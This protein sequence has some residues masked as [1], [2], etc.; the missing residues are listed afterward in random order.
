M[1]TLALG[2]RLSEDIAR[3][4]LLTV[5]LAGR[6]APLVHR[7]PELIRAARRLVCSPPRV[8]VK[9]I[10][11]DGGRPFISSTQITA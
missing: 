6:G 8:S 4:P 3:G 5:Q 1:L 7:C 9:I 2:I 11:N 10:M